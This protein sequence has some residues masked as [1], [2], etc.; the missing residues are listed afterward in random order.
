M[1]GGYL[2]LTVDEKK[3][4]HLLFLRVD[5]SFD[6]HLANHKALNIGFIFDLSS[7]LIDGQTLGLISSFQPS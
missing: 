2:Y 7:E 6:D 4:R 1:D 3:I 5:N